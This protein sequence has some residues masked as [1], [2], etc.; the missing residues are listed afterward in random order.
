MIY[1]PAE[2]TDVCYHLAT[3]YYFATERQLDEPVFMFWHTTPTIVIGKY[4][5]TLQELNQA[6]VDTHPVTVVR[7]L[8]GGGTVYYDLGGWC[9]SFVVRDGQEEISFERFLLP[10]QR[11]L[12]EL[13]L[14]TEFSGRN[15]LLLDGKKFSGN[16]QYRI[17][18]TTVHHGTLMYSVDLEAM[19]AATQVDPEKFSSKGI[20]SVR[21]RVTN[22]AEHLDAGSKP[23]SEEFGAL[24][25]RHIAKDATV[26]VP[27]AEEKK[28]INE[29][30]DEMFRP[31][32]RIYGGNPKATYE[33][34]RRFGGGT[35]AL[36]MELKQ[37]KILSARFSGDFFATEQLPELEAKLVGCRYEKAAVLEILKQ[38]C[39]DAIYAVSPEE[40]LTLFFP[41]DAL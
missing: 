26:Y 16:A 21:S 13:G 9:Y 39:G 38:P 11:A 30:A 7:R 5:N 24:L 12:A 20:R 28:R 35:V 4:Q 14:K 3:E 19:V 15:D 23:T 41:D 18:G 36:G 37:G 6:Y 25:V 10:V 27:S 33:C 32:E 34:K 40:L 22:L 31:W 8:S 1:I 29:I 2:N 17:H